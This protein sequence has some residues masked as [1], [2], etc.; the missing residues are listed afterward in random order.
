MPIERPIAG[1]TEIRPVLPMAVAIETPKM[2]AKARFWRP[3]A[4]AALGMLR[5]RTPRRRA[6]I[7]RPPGHAVLSNN[8]HSP[9]TFGGPY[10]SDYRHRAA[11]RPRVRQ[12]HYL[13]RQHRCDSSRPAARDDGDRRRG[14]RG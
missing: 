10:V 13:R 9:R 4:G 6:Q 3:S 8:G 12:L 2:I 7:P 14:D 11:V 1:S 5:L